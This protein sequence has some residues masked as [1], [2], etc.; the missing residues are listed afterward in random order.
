M[1]LDKIISLK[2]SIIESANLRIKL[3][4]IKDEI[5]KIDPKEKISYDDVDVRV[6][7]NLIFSYFYELSSA[8]FDAFVCEGGKSYD[9]SYKSFK[10][11]YLNIYY[12]FLKDFFIQDE[13]ITKFFKRMPERE[14][15]NIYAMCEDSLFNFI[16]KYFFDSESNKIGIEHIL[17][18]IITYDCDSVDKEIRYKNILF[19]HYKETMISE[20]TEYLNRLIEK[21]AEL[22]RNFCSAKKELKELKSCY[23]VY[24]SLGDVFK[25]NYSRSE[26]K[27]KIIPHEKRYIIKLN[28]EYKETLEL[29]KKQ[30]KKINHYKKLTREQ[31]EGK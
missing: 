16:A 27:D 15:C 9:Y 19:M 28:I 4:N 8:V 17:N 5:K 23:Y 10:I 24:N 25:K 20:E 18:N 11:F 31:F 26:L 6:I 14:Y 21:S 2:K 22:Q 29:I 30:I 3:E 12:S 1:I 7:T 13:T